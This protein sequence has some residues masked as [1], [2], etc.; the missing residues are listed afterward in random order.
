MLPYGESV[1]QVVIEVFAKGI[2]SSKP[3][4]CIH[5]ELQHEYVALVVLKMGLLVKNKT[6]RRHAHQGCPLRRRACLR[7]LSR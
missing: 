4:S 5:I 6:P 3:R 2:V 7:L 1:L